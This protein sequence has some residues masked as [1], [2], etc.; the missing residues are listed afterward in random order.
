VFGAPLQ[1]LG[2]VCKIDFGT[3]IVKSNNTDGEYPVFGSGRATFSTTT[4]NREGY[5]VLIGRFALSAECVRLI[6]A[7]IFLNDSGLSVKPIDTIQML[8]KYIGYY[9]HVN[10]DVIYACARGTAQKNLDI[11]KFRAIQIPIPSLEQ[12]R[13]I[14]EFCEANDGLIRQL[15]QE[16]D[17][18]ETFAHTFV[19]SACKKRKRDTV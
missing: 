1:T 19:Q 17:K 8:H 13:E 9:L 14:V 11:D 18:N 6:N 12:Q 2:E 16:I 10:Q 4:F 15:E 7:K 3:R 5:N